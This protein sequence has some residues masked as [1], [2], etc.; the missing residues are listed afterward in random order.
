MTLAIYWKHTYCLEGPDGGR[1]LQRVSSRVRGEEIASYLDA[2]ANPKVCPSDVVQIHVKPRY[3]ESLPTGAY[4]DLLDDLS[5]VERLKSRRDIRLV[6]M[7]RVLEEYLHEQLP[8]HEIVYIPHHH[9]NFERTRRESRSIKRCGYVGVNNIFQQTSARGIGRML[10]QVGLEFESLF[11]FER[12]EDILA[13]YQ[14]IDLQVIPLFGFRTDW[15]TGH[16][17]KIWNA[18]SF[19]IPTIAWPVRGYAEATGYYLPAADPEDMA[20]KA[21]AIAD[22]THYDLWPERLIAK[23]EEYHI[24]RIAELYRGLR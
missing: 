1:Y 22:G 6:A 8:E 4:V 21:R 24:E 17:T 3:P 16:P 19:G 23:A 2:L 10:E 13:F 18:A 20:K 15:P 14:R 11:N 7:T 9:V 12:R 5:Y